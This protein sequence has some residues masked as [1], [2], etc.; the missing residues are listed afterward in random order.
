MNETQKKKKK[1]KRKDE[2]PFI[3]VYF[4]FL[5]EI[6]NREKRIPGTQDVS[7]LEN[8][9]DYI[10]CTRCPAGPAVWVRSTHL[11]DFLAA[12]K[13]GLSVF[14]SLGVQLVHGGGSHVVGSLWFL[15]RTQRGHK[16]WISDSTS[17]SSFDKQGFNS[18]HRISDGLFVDY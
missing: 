9:S 3:Y 4:L 18:K 1:K 13:D 6:E 10:I 7:V 11:L 5:V 17:T 8:W 16:S 15:S 2:A 14:I 12:F